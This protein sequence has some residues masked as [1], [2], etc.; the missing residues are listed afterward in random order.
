MISI[1]SEYLEV[2]DVEV[3]LDKLEEAYE[4]IGQI[5]E[6]DV[7]FLALALAVECNGIWTEDKHF[8]NQQKVRIW[9]TKDVIEWLRKKG[10]NQ[11]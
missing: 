3:Y 11:I 1:L 5:D 7:P 4:L 8:R 6:G 9:K 2:I 10:T